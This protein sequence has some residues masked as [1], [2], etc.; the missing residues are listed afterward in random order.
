MKRRGLVLFAVI[1]AAMVAVTWVAASSFTTSAQKAADAEAPPPSI[2]TA[3]ITRD[4]L[5]TTVPV[6]CTVGYGS[7]FTVQAPATEDR[8]QY[9][10]LAVTSH[11]DIGQGSLLAEVNGKPLFAMVGGFELYRDLR[12][13]D[14]GPDARQLNESLIALGFQGPRAPAARDLIDGHTFEAL[15]RLYQRFGYEPIGEKDIIPASSFLYLVHPGTVVGEPRST[16]P[17]SLG[18]IATLSPDGARL[19]CTGSGGQLTPEASVGQR[20]MVPS[21]GTTE[22]AVTGVKDNQASQQ[23]GRP[24]QQGISSTDQRT[25]APNA[26]QDSVADSAE[27]PGRTGASR[28]TDSGA[29]GGPAADSGGE[30]AGAE[31]AVLVDLGADL[32]R[33]QGVV[34]G[35]LILEESR[36]RQLVVPSSG[37]WTKDGQTR[38]TVAQGQETHDVPVRVLFSADGRNAVEPL[39]GEQNNSLLDEGATIRVG[40][41]RGGDK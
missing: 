33:I 39:E 32:D 25:P 5:R 16:G 13:E 24:D 7:T 3:V 17:V 34:S 12:A 31:R 2:L 38:V 27:G 8:S 19:E 37:L 26:G 23:T 15:G 29:G 1:L 30:G 28:P 36:P 35:Q 22:Y 40:I 21:L 41:D 4:Q 10:K 9:T 14:R 20:V 11:E 6:N 18:P